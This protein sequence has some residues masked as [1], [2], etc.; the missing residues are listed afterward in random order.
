VEDLRSR[1]GK[2][3][4][5]YVMSQREEVTATGLQRQTEVVVRQL[6]IDECCDLASGL[7]VKLACVSTA[8]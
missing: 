3:N 1:D 8:Y 5:R 7:A 6:S 4:D 2:S